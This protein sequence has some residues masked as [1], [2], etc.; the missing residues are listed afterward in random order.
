M[1][2]ACLVVTIVCALMVA[3]SRNGKQGRDRHHVRVI[4][5]KNGSQ[6]RV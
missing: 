4:H 3:F 6:P 5:P 2:I 1:L